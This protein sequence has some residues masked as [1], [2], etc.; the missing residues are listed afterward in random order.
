MGQ[1]P[2]ATAAIVGA[3]T[4][5]GKPSVSYATAAPLDTNTRTGNV[6]T[7]DANGELSVDGNS[8]SV[9]DRILVK[10]EAVGDNNGIYV[11]TDAGSGSTP[12]VLTRASDANASYK[13]QQG[14]L[15]AAIGGTANAGKVFRLDTPNPIILNTTGLEFVDT[16]AVSLSSATPQALG[17]ADAGSA[18]SAARGDHVHS[19]SPASDGDALGSAALR[20]VPWVSGLKAKRN[21]KTGDYTLTGTDYYV[22]FDISSAKTAT[23]PSASTNEEQVFIIKNQETSSADLTVS[24]TI[25]GVTNPTLIPG[26]SMTIISTGFGMTGYDLIG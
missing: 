7:A 15:V 5:L 17:T 13:I 12:W 8:P 14:L 26:A 11:V 23:L 16:T 25:G 24:G 21:A 19:S 18:S 6:L 9:S 2:L 1:Y 20:W 22:P 3:F 10:D 4:L